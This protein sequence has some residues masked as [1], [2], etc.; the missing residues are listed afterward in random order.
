METMQSAVGHPF[1]TQQPFNHGQTL[2]CLPQY[3]S[4]SICE[5]VEKRP[6]D[7][8]KKK[9]ET[10]CYM[11]AAMEPCNHMEPQLV[12][13]P[14]AREHA[15]KNIDLIWEELPPPHTPLVTDHI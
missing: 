1:P 8:K 10:V 15:Q 3:V 12:N 6:K 14:S 11:C 9:S 13:I 7:H 5:W 4:V 2:A